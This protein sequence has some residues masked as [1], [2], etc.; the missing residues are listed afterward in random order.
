MTIA[1]SPFKLVVM[2][3]G[4]RGREFILKEGLNLAGR[5]DPES[6]SFPEIDLT[7]EDV[8]AKVSRK[9]AVFN[10]SK[11]QVTLEDQSS[12]NGTYVNRGPKLSPGVKCRLHL[13]DEIVIGKVFL[14]LE[15]NS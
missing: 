14:L 11:E 3:G 1:F 4:I 9:H 7:N 12:L 13:E 8:D 15:K 6:G 10:A 2:R 5:W